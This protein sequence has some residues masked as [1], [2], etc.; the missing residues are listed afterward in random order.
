MKKAFARALAAVMLLVCTTVTAWGEPAVLEPVPE[1]DETDLNC[2]LIAVGKDASPTGYVIVGHN[3]DDSGRIKMRH[4][5][6]EP[7]TWPAGTA[8]PAENGRAAIPQVENTFGFFWSQAKAAT[9]GFSNADGFLNEN[10]VFLVSN[11][12]ASSKQS[13]S[14]P[15]R[16]TDGG[17]EY[18]LRRVVAERAT[19]AR[20]ACEIIIDMVETYGYAPSGRAYTVADKNEIWMVQIVSGK[21][22][23]AVRVPDDHVAV[24]PNHYT[25]H[26]LDE[27]EDILY[28]DKLVEYAIEM[29]WYTPA[30]PG[31]Y[32]DFDF[33]YVYQ[34]AGSY[35]AA[36]NTLRQKYAQAF[37]LGEVVEDYFPFSV[38]VDGKVSLETVK[39][40]L[41][42]HYEGT[43]DDPADRRIPPGNAP[44]DTNIRRIC[45]GATIESAICQFTADPKLTTLWM[46]F[47]RPCELP[48][49]PLHPLTGSIPVEI[50]QMEDPAYELATHLQP[51]PPLMAYENTGWQ[52]FRNFQGMLEMVYDQHIESV[53]ALIKDYM[54]E[55]YPANLA[56]VASGDL[57]AAAQFDQTVTSSALRMLKDYANTV[58]PVVPLE[59]GYIN[60]VSPQPVYDLFFTM[61]GGAQPAES[62]LRFGMNF[63][64]TSSQYVSP[65]AGSLTSLG[66]NRW[67][68]SFTTA[69]LASRAPSAGVYEHIF[70]GRTTQGEG[71]TGLL[72]LQ[73]TDEDILAPTGD[74]QLATEAH[75][76]KAGDY[77]T[78]GTAFVKQMSSNTAVLT[79][80]YDDSLFEY[81]NFVPAEGVT[82]IDIT[83]AAGSA[84]VTVAAMNYDLQNVGDLMLHAK[85]TAKLSNEYQSLSVHIAYVLRNN[86]WVKSIREDTA[87]VSFTTVG[88]GGGG[89]PAV[90][91]DTDGDGLVD[92]RDL[93][94]IIDM[95][96]V[97]ST[98]SQWTIRYVFFDFNNNG[99]IDISDIAYVAKLIQ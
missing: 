70:G 78:V 69:G 44:H 73:F 14:D 26:G 41:S 66:E 87:S 22:Y 37:L 47:G 61:P 23:V 5:Y 76:V 32:S 27:Y 49:I 90:P 96:G 6:V 25:V 65:I 53:G 81:A 79:Y 19:S 74:L 17:I 84:K 95:F 72:K 52:E 60:R 85:P 77:F 13:T 97:G 51:N 42:Y 92:L 18:N 28:S 45:T 11:S 88:N 86:A 39:A 83:H 62:S 93:S 8:L 48:Y 56:L 29:G 68:V 24:M 1:A 38:K 7:A 71:F 94:N 12:N 89:Q 9:G 30:V 80:T 67:K 57:S 20:H 40:I 58:I 36:A 34:A 50:Q 15:A 91:G 82:V 43:V 21:H 64:N 35:K 75:H 16:L 10:G 99:T 98:D 59:G 63:L 2:M 33:A 4:G 55:L 31:D 54:D 46:A 3:E